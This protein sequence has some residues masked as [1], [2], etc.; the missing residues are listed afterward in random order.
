TFSVTSALASSI[1]SRIKVEVFS[2]TSKTSSPTVRCSGRGGC[3]GGED[4]A[5][6]ALATRAGPRWRAAARPAPGRAPRW[7]WRGPGDARGEDAGECAA[8]GEHAAPDQPADDVVVHSPTLPIAARG[9]RR[10]CP[11]PTPWHG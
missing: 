9:R 7:R 11:P 4:G 10:S 5:T 8:A 6:A 1:S 2:E 3:G